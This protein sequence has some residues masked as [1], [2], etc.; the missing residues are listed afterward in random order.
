MDLGK[1]N[2][3]LDEMFKITFNT[4]KLKTYFNYIEQVSNKSQQLVEDVNVKIQRVEDT[5][6]NINEYMDKFESF[7]SRIEKIYQ[8]LDSYQSKFLEIDQRSELLNKVII[9]LYNF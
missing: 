1:P 5:S 8:T 6:N 3:N 9:Y 7:N 2:M 4:D